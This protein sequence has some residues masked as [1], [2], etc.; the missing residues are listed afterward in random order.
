MKLKLHW[1]ILIAMGL[2]VLFAMI[3]GEK[4]GFIAPVGNIFIRL[5]KMVIVPLVM[6]S[7]ISGVASVGN[8]KNLGRLG[9]KTISYYLLTSLMAIL[10]GLTLVNLI[11]PGRGVDIPSS[12]SISFEDLNKPDSLSDIFI[13]M[14]PD[15]PVGAAANGDMLGI[16]FFA[17]VF[18]AVLTK[19]PKQYGDILIPLIDSLFHAM[20]KLTGYIIKLAPIGVF[21]LIVNAINATGFELFKAVGKYMITITIGLTIHFL[22]ILPVIYW[23]FTKRNPVDHFKNM[24]NALVTAFSTSSS[25]VT[26]PVT[27]DCVESNAGVSNKISSFVLPMGATINM[28]GTA[29]YECAGVLFIAQVMGVDLSISQQL[30][31]VITALLASIGAAG[32]PSAGLVMIFIVLSAVG[33]QGP[34]VAMIVGTMLAVDRPLDMYRTMVNIFSDSVGA[35]VIA[36]SESEISTPNVTR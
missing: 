17:I 29:L 21:G 26:L 16:I 18:G 8:A 2:G 28:D 11:A 19:V 30:I 14:I 33:L 27:M 4:S 20:M 12:K 10:I 7:I 32:I 34:T 6:T 36:N 5:L 15:N 25:S 9:L 31:V 23:I 3:L 13:R 24:A 35:V 22:I 1:Q